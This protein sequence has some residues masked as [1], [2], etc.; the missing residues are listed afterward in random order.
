[1]H[2]SRGNGGKA[3]TKT[4]ERELNEVLNDKDDFSAYEQ[5]WYGVSGSD[6]H[7]KQE[8]EIKELRSL[9]VDVETR[10]KRNVQNIDDKQEHGGT[11]L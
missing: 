5:D 2:I 7:G 3:L 1:M 4:Y 9:P 11:E 10:S 8:A 6:G